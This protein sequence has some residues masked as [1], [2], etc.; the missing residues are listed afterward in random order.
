[1]NPNYTGGR[2][3]TLN[4]TTDPAN[5][6]TL[7]VCGSNEFTILTNNSIYLIILF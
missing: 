7:Y 3:D 1:M 2:M 4:T 5:T 6:P